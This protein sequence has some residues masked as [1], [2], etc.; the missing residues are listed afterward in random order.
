MQMIKHLNPAIFGFFFMIITHLFD[1]DTPTHHHRTQQ[2]QRHDDVT[3]NIHAL[4]FR[5]AAF[6]S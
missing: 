2:H 6:A 4:Q 3:M 1:A 5:A